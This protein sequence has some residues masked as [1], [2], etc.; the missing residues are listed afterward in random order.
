[1]TAQRKPLIV[2][3]LGGNAV[4]PPRGDLGLGV[5]RMLIDRAAADLAEVAR[6]GARLLVVHGNGPQVGRLLG[7]C[8]TDPVDLDIRVAQ[9][10]GELG[11]L[12]AEALS[13]YGGR[14]DTAAMMTR[15]LVDPNDPAFALPSK[16]I[17]AV[18]PVAPEGVPSVR[19]SDG[20][21]WRRIVA[22]P[23]PISVIE[24]SA[25][26]AL[27][28]THHVIAGGGGGVPLCGTDG[29]RRPQAAVV[30][31]DWVAALLAI[32]LDAER[33]LFV[34][35]VPCVFDRYGRFDRQPIKRLA[36]SDARAR[37]TAGAFTPGSMAPKIES[38]VQFVEAAG[39]DHR[40]RNARGCRERQRWHD[41]PRSNLSPA[42]AGAP[43]AW[44][45]QW[46]SGSPFHRRILPRAGRWR[47]RSPCAARADQGPS[48]RAGTGSRSRASL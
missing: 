27:L 21:G 34:T 35:D 29:A 41:N 26:A 30:D 9:T 25:I 22:S 12:L 13:R 28:S 18:L 47:L 23:R 6:S 14:D 10:Q 4:S 31:K 42:R 32:S 37:L 46:R 5:E 15:V 1:V 20:S 16:P 44:H 2:V 24:Q 11:Y 33:L 48:W 8:D 40:P 45:G 17:G 3:A 36:V 7:T 39:R 43:T 19:M 38:A